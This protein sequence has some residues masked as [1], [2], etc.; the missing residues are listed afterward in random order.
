MQTQRGFTLIELMVTVSILGIIL[1]VAMP[2]YKEFSSSSIRADECIRPLSNLAFREEK[3]K[4][5]QNTYTTTLADLN[6]PAT[7]SEGHY[8]FSVVAGTTGDIRTSFR[9]SCVPDPAQNVDPNC[10]TL[11][12]DN[13]G[14]QT[15][16]GGSGCWR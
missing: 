9:A 1:A 3:Y 2:S 8:T 4:G 12:I 14:A 10:G 6:V 15:A 16:T 13:F 7:S 11:S 5:L